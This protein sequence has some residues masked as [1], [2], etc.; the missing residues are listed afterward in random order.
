MNLSILKADKKNLN[1]FIA[2]GS[3]LIFIGFI[4]NLYIS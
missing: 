2:I 4:M 3:V 1:T